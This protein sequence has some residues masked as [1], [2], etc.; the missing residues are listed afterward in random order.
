[1]AVSILT[2]AACVGRLKNKNG[3]GQGRESSPLRTCV[4]VSPDILCRHPMTIQTSCDYT[5]ILRLYRYRVTI[6][7]S[8]D[9]TEI[10]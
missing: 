5:D 6:Q 4:I 7:K 1:M 9:Y 10:L 3:T 8:Y 2:Y